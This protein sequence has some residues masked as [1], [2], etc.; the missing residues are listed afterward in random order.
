MSHHHQKSIHFSLQ[1]GIGKQLHAENLLEL[2]HCT[3]RLD[4]V[5]D[6]TE[7]AATCSAHVGQQVVQEYALCR[8]C[9]ESI[10]ADLPDAA[11]E[12]VVR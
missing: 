3:M 8:L 7:A 6:V 11:V 2:A 4:N 10:E 5:N 12:K 9:A 1:P